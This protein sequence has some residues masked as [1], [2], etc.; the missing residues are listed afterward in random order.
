MSTFC[1]YK[2]KGTDRQYFIAAILYRIFFKEPGQ[3]AVPQ[4]QP[5]QQLPQQ[6]QQQWTQQQQQ[7]QQMMQQQQQQGMQQPRMMG[8][9]VFLPFFYVISGGENIPYVGGLTYIII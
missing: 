6:Q 2:T 5:G 1:S 9:Q 7:Q 8:G 3:F 4:G